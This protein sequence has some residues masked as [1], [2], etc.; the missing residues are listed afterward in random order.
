MGHDSQTPAEV[1][2]TFGALRAQFSLAQAGKNSHRNSYLVQ[3]WGKKSLGWCDGI[4]VWFIEHVWQCGVDIQRLTGFQFTSE[5]AF[6]TLWDCLGLG[7]SQELQ[8]H[9]PE[10]KRLHL[11]S[12]DRAQ[13]VC[14]HV[15]ERANVPPAETDQ[16]CS[17]Q[18]QDELAPR[19]CRAEIR[20]GFIIWAARWRTN[21]LN[22]S[23][24][25]FQWSAV[26]HNSNKCSWLSP[27]IA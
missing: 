10:N 5:Q 4:C 22:P 17:P 2:Y 9:V 18:Q 1:I 12:Q 19:G 16:L 13:H 14:L 21:T 7:S 11:A 26:I 3:L 15:N 8:T 24:L 25:C 23:L 27:D 6:V 20:L